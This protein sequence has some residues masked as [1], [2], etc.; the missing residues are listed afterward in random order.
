MAQ[1]RTRSE[2]AE[3]V[4]VDLLAAARREFLAAGYHAAT[5]DKIAAAAGYTKG[6]VYS[7]YASKADLFLA[8]LEE[9]I[10]A[11]A[12]QNR[13]MAAEVSG[14]DELAELVARWAEVQQRDLPWSLLV[15]EFR[16]HAARDPELLDRYAALHRRTLDGI[17]AV[18]GGFLPATA[19][20]PSAR[21][22]AQAIF[23]AGT[24]ATLEQA[25]DPSPLPHP[26]IAR[27]VGGLA[28]KEVDR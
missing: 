26:V 23:A 21:D 16:V 11:R 9:R 22:V 19:D 5:L 13:A 10:E 28:P 1:R 24:G 12:E 18:L 6:A 4:R 15:I 27:M 14:A 20:G 25:V 2:Q 8:L 7:R 3:Q 17:A